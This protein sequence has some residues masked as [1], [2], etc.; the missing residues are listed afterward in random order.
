[1]FQKNKTKQET[2]SNYSSWL[3]HVWLL[4]YF[5]VKMSNWAWQLNTL[6]QILQL[7]GA[8][9]L[10]ALKHLIKNVVTLF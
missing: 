9:L 3:V 6:A 8:V 7:T 1:M 4:D 5:H 10:W 2:S